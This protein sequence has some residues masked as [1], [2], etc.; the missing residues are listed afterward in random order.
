LALYNTPTAIK[1]IIPL[2][3]GTQGGGQQA[4]PPV[5]LPG[6]GAGAA[7]IA[8]A[9]KNNIAVKENFKVFI[10]DYKCIKNP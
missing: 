3:I 2:S 10:I 1:K 9:P 6:G 4:G 8:L 5:V 7:K